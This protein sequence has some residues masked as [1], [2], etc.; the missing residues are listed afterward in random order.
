MPVICGD[1]EQTFHAACSAP[2]HAAMPVCYAAAVVCFALAS[3]RIYMR[4]QRGRNIGQLSRS[5]E[6]HETFVVLY[7]DNQKNNINRCTQSK[8]IDN[9]IKV[10]YY[11]VID[12]LPLLT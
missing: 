12:V 8:E 7:R 11:C 10:Y 9:F 5:S 6:A 4:E 2:V 3:L 1:D